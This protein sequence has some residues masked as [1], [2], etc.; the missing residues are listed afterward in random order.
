MSAQNPKFVENRSC[1]VFISS[2]IQQVNCYTGQTQK[3]RV[4]SNLGVACKRH[5]GLAK[6]NFIRNHFIVGNAGRYS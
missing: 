3:G 4:C 5:R 2:A 1:M 6:M